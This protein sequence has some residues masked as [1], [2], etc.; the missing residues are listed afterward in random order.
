[1]NWDT[2]GLTSR[3]IIL[4]SSNMSQVT[5]HMVRF[6]SV[7]DMLDCVPIVMTSTLNIEALLGAA[8]A[9]TKGAFCVCKTKP[10]TPLIYIVWSKSRFIKKRSLAARQ[11]QIT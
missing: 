9:R 4:D 7:V 5:A 2:T 11:K 8:T 10:D 6:L 3:S 1:M